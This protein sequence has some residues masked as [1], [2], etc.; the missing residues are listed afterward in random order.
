MEIIPSIFFNYNAMRL[1]IN[2][3]GKKAAKEKKKWVM[4]HWWNQW[5][6]KKYLETNENTN[7][8]IQSLFTGHSSCK[9][10][11]YSDTNLTQEERKILNLVP[12]GTRLKRWANK[13]QS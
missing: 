4:G 9:T 12:K 8:L 7:T 1:V 11:A 2:Y 10:N 6:K 3:E 5:R 13:T